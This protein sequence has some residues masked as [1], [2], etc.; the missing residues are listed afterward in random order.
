MSQQL[1]LALDHLVVAAATL[2]A[3][4]AYVREAT[5]LAMPYGGAHSVMATHN[6][7]MRLGEDCFLE[8]IAPDPAREPERARWYALEDPPTAP[9]LA[10][11]ALR[12]DDLDA[13]L[14]LLPPEFG[15]P[16][17]VSR[18]TLSWRF[19]VADDGSLPH[20]GAVPALIEWPH[21]ARPWEGMADLG[22][23]LVR[24]TVEHPQADAIAV[25]LRPHLADLRLVYRAG[26]R[27]RLRA[28]LL[29]PRG[30]CAL[31]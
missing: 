27:V 14:A 29:A 3:G 13:A 11:F 19:A 22:A 7:L 16:I 21:G 24:L 6:H 23:S 31:G 9:M 30:P 5:G 18:G 4:V 26:P 10:T 12:T 20:Q 1:N 17:E 25:V 15:R 28:E 8:A 2:E